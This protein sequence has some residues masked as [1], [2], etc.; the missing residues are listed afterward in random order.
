VLIVL[1]ATYK[2]YVL[3]VHCVHERN[4]SLI[5]YDLLHCI[6]CTE[7]HVLQYVYAKIYRVYSIYIVYIYHIVNTL[8]PLSMC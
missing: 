6:L 2:M 7:S 5:V 8:L 1:H 3:C 4:K